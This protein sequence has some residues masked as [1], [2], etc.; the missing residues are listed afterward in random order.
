MVKGGDLQ[1]YLALP[2]CPYFVA[3]LEYTPQFVERDGLETRAKMAPHLYIWLKITFQQTTQQTKLF[4]CFVSLR[5]FLWSNL[6][7]FLWLNL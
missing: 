5:F 2:R 7:F 6:R 3:R 1:L 4:L